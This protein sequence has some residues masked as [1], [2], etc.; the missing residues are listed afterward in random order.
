MEKQWLVWILSNPVYAEIDTSKQDVPTINYVS[1]DQHKDFS[2]AR[3]ERDFRDTRKF[4]KTLS[5]G[6]PF[7]QRN[8][9]F[10]LDSGGCAADSVNAD[11]AKYVDEA[12]VADI[13]GRSNCHHFK[14][15]CIGSDTV[16]IEL[17][18]QWLVTAGLNSVGLEPTFELVSAMQLSTSLIWFSLW[19]IS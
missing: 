4:M 11:N 3:L 7:T 12:I 17:R 19:N 9:S 14:K 13:V 18:F 2:A 5:M 6:F 1:S 16:H 8:G 10:H 15:I